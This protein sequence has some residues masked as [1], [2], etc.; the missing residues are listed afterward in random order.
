M[1]R[2]FMYSMVLVGLMGGACQSA[3][4]RGAAES[5]SGENWCA[6]GQLV[7]AGRIHLTP[8][9]LVSERA[10]RE[11]DEGGSCE[12]DGGQFDDDYEI[13]K[14]KAQQVCSAFSGP[15]DTRGADFGNVMFL[16]DRPLQFM[17]SRQ[18][19][20]Y[21]LDMGLMGLCVRC[22]APS[23]GRSAVFQ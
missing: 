22:D 10:R 9:Y 23:T 18:Y 17:N 2:Q 20:E 15:S 11:C 7:E 6:R 13:G 19:G 5:S 12:R 1:I 3:M 16:P 21:R 4:A 8:Y 14:E